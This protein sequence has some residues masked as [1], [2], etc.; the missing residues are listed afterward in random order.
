MKN[1]LSWLYDSTFHSDI[2]IKEL[3]HYLS[4]EYSQYYQIILQNDMKRYGTIIFNLL[5]SGSSVIM[6]FHIIFQKDSTIFARYTKALCFEKKG[7][8]KRKCQTLPILLRS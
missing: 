6:W 2:Y 7:E 3:S 5:E 4:A 8:A 1:T